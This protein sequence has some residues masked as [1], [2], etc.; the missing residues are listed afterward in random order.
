MNGS[1]KEFYL[2]HGLSIDN[3]LENTVTE[4]LLEDVLHDYWEGI[5]SSALEIEDALKAEDY[6][7]YTVKVHAL[8][9]SS[10]LVGIM[11]LGDEAYEYEL[12]GYEAQKGDEAAIA[13][14]KNGTSE[15]LSKYRSYKEIFAPVF[16]G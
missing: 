7:L 14:I 1:L 8:K 5:E 10:R 4:E 13:K 12:T 6:K 15:L 3:A 2:S 11:G 16:N 9:S